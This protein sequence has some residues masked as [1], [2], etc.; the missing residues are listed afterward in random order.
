MYAYPGDLIDWQDLHAP[1]RWPE[2]RLADKLP[3][4]DATHARSWPGEQ[5]DKRTLVDL[6]EI[7]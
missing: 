7:R 4:P 2:G 5:P 6:L 1:A 3:R